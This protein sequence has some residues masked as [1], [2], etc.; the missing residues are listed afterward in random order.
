MTVADTVAR[1]RAE[2]GKA[3]VGQE[4]AIEQ[5]VSAF[6]AD[7]HVLLE[8]VPG[9]AKTLLVRS[10]SMVF[11]LTFTRIQFTPD[12]M[13]S[14]VIGTEVFDPRDVTFKLREGPVFTAVLLADEINRTPPKT[15]AALLEA[16][17]ER[18][19]TIGGVRRELP[20]PFLV[21]ATQ[22]PIEFEGTYPLPEAQQ[23]RF[24]LKVVLDYPSAEAEISVLKRFHAGFRSQKLDDAGIQPVVDAEGLRAMRREVEAVKVEE[25]I[26]N[27]VY[28]IVSATR[29]SHDVLVGA[30]PRA[31][32]ALVA[33][34][35]AVAAV[36]GRDF[37]IP[38]DVKE[39]A[40][41][42]L[43]HRVVLRPETE[44]E[45]LSSDMVLRG[46]IDDVEVP[47]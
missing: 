33:C 3:V 38:D 45:G 44:I 47:R 23:D 2:V 7:G 1:I 29:T 24:L 39:L 17:E 18:Q 26:F 4:T 21:F 12:L 31:G 15:Q 40:L 27:Y 9:L 10:L 8:G 13:P 5:A 30:S 11:D 19:A 41:P 34:S 35:K 37:V 14:D 25:K 20:F 6:L 22:N 43:R 42:V 28:S 46:L 36:R 32:L 16:M